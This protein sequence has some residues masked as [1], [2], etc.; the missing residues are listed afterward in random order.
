MLSTPVMWLVSY[1][2]TTWAWLSSD[3]WCSWHWIPLHSSPIYIWHQY[4]EMV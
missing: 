1:R 2:V 4:T 3:R